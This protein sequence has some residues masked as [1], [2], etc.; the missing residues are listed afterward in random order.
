[1]VDGAAIPPGATIPLIPRT[2]GRNTIRLVRVLEQ[3]TQVGIPL[4]RAL[5]EGMGRFPV[6][7]VAWYSDDWMAPRYTPFFHLH[8]GLDIFADFGS[9][10]RSPDEGTVTRITDGPIG[11]LAV[12]MTGRDGLQY[13]F[14]HLQDYAAGI[15]AGVRVQV[16]TVIGFVGDSGNA[17]GGAPHLHLEIHKGGPLPP[18]PYVDA[19]LADAET[20]AQ[21]WVESHIQQSL[22]ER[23]LLRSEHALAPLL[24]ADS[25]APL[26]TPEY[27]LMLT[28]LDPIAGAAGLIPRIAIVPSRTG[29]GSTRLLEE[30]IRQRV[31]GSIL[32][33][34]AGAGSSRDAG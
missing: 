19:W 33:S 15:A 3:V 23:Q 18:K 9:P 2:P 28:L 17:R 20:Q 22:A 21:T 34:L 16:G 26:P 27:S 11:G 8:E 12:W 24:A 6:A 1:M 30:L 7:G 25:G 10:V 32:A 4:D 31:D 5:L 29:S 13:Y 14:A